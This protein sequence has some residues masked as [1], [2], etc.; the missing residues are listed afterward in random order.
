MSDTTIVK[1][2]IQNI[3]IS[4]IA[5]AQRQLDA[6]IRMFFAREDD[7]AVH[8]VA[9]AAFTVLRN[10]IENNGHNFAEEAFRTGLLDLARRYAAGTL[11][12]KE[13][14]LVEGSRLMA[15]F[16]PLLDDI[17]MQGDEFDSKRIILQMSTQEQQRMFPSMTA[18][19]LKHADRDPNGWLALDSV[20]NENL[21][22][23]SCAAYVSLMK[24]PT[25]EVMTF[26]TFWAA[27][28]S[29]ADEVA[30]N[31]QTF[32]KELKKAAPTQRYALRS[33]FIREY[34]A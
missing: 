7:L 9:A 33:R 31:L 15:I 4:K 2:T 3:Q 26:F 21:L 22:M 30:P 12:P 5:A 1:A 14:A 20:N 29:S 24:Q 17:R 11:P 18:N 34:P 27:K 25:V 28:H 8:T 32:V 16:E 10:L 13:K 23:A 19:F 6:A